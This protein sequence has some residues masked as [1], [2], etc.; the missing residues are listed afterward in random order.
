MIYLFIYW[1]TLVIIPWDDGDQ[2]YVK[3]KAG[4]KLKEIPSK[5]GEEA[6]INWT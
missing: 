2:R 3:A 5:T 4:R 6:V 1:L